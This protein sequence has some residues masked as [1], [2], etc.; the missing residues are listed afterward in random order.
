MRTASGIRIYKLNA[1]AKLNLY[2]DITGRRDDGYHLLET[3]MQSISLADEV[4]VVVSAGNGIT[5]SVSR[6]DIPTDGRNTAFRAAELFLEKAGA[7]GSVCIDI[8]KRIPSGAGMGGGSADAAAVLKAL[9]TAFGE[10]LS[11]SELL[12]IAE[13]V[14]ADVPFCLIGGTKLCRGIGEQMSDIPVTEGVF[15]VVKPEFGC[16][17]GEAYRKYDE[18]PLEIHGG[19]ERFIAGLPR[20]YAPEMYS[21]FQ[22]LYSDRR[23]EDICARLT[24][25]GAKGAMLTGSGSAVFGVF[26]NEAN[27]KRASGEFPGCFTAV[28][29]CVR[30]GVPSQKGRYYDQGSEQYRYDNH[31]AGLLHIAHRKHRDRLLRRCSDEYQ[32]RKADDTCGAALRKEEKL[33]ARHKRP[34]RA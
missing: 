10:P 20:N 32:Q 27:A 12:G 4:T 30:E 14:G 2:L 22:K 18:S 17:T 6:E 31:F 26:D 5:L 7:S 25:L 8:E 11:E 23:I 16:P 21:V 3:V 9:N 19:L 1:Y 15:L 28:S 34:R 29:G 24:A 33:R 13:Q